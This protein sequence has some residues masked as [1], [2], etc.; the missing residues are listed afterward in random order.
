MPF[1]TEQFFTVFE[2]YNAAIWPM[3]MVAYALATAA[4]LLSVPE[5]LGLAVAAAIMLAL[6]A[7]RWMWAWSPFEAGMHEGTRRTT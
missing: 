3:Q 5:D 7:R 6:L 2:S 4:A 1:A